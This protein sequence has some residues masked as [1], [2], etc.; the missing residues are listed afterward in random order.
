MRDKTLRDVVADRPIYKL[1]GYV[2]R[3]GNSDW[4]Y[5]RPDIDSDFELLESDFAIS[6]NTISTDDG[7]G[8]PVGNVVCR[9][10][11]LRVV[12]SERFS[13]ADFTDACI[14]LGC[15]AYAADGSVYELTGD[16]YFVKSVDTVDGQITIEAGDAVS[17]A[18]KP[19]L[20]NIPIA[21]RDVTGIL[22]SAVSQSGMAA[23]TVP[24]GITYSAP[25][26]LAIKS[27]YTCRQIIGF[28]AM[29]QGANA[30]VE[31]GRPTIQLKELYIASQ[32]ID[33]PYLSQ[34]IRFT[35]KATQIA[36]TG[37]KAIRYTDLNGNELETP[38]EFLS[39][40]YSD[41]F[42]VQFEN[43]F[44]LG[45]ESAYFARTLNRLLRSDTKFNLFTGTYI[46]Y[47][48]AEYG[49]RVI[50]WKNGEALFDT[51]L[52][53][54]VWNVSGTTEFACNIRT[55][56]ANSV[57]YAGGGVVIPENANV[58]G[59][60]VIE[61]NFDTMS[62]FKDRNG[63]T[64]TA[65]VKRRWRKWSSG[66]LEQWIEREVSG[67]AYTSKLNDALYRSAAVPMPPY[68]VEFVDISN[69]VVGCNHDNGYI[70]WMIKYT[71]G[72]NT[73]PPDIAGLRHNN[74]G[75]LS[76]KLTAYTV[77]TWE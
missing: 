67:E 9:V 15:K 53:K 75:T 49:D 42:P 28:V 65:D 37:L 62:N 16:Y 39:D 52:T 3:R 34:W 11:K 71:Q 70:A 35:D 48:L 40:G 4:R 10:A 51:F 45:N 72:T 12:K 20:P 19:F 60:V 33:K 47:P 21:D 55:D 26:R 22:R 56:A 54:I 77:G 8:F 50:V 64:V 57:A 73:H 18:D 6:G 29:T 46:S 23:M 43:P 36:V 2:Y 68:A 30:I 59:D 66:L 7:D 76:G 32:S 38:Q 74:S 58:V 1:H 69:C 14:F 24:E 17:L 61:S 5:E 13:A 44:M 63:N 41:V 25:I 31:A 27:G